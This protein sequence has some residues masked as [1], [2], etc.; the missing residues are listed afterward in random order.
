MKTQ[1]ILRPPEEI[2][3][4]LEDQAKKKEL[5]INAVTI[6]ILWDKMISDQKGTFRTI[7]LYCMIFSQFSK[8]PRPVR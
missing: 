6:Q 1:L 5:S 2:K 4:W 3:H 8:M 7:S